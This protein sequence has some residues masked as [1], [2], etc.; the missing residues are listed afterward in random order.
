MNNRRINLI[1]IVVVIVVVLILMSML[2]GPQMGART[3]TR[4]ISC[5][6]NLSSIG[7]AT[8][9]YESQSYYSK[10][11]SV[12]DQQILTNAETGLPI[13]A[14]FRAELID[15]VKVITCP[16]GDSPF[17]V[18]DRDDSNRGNNVFDNS[19]DFSLSPNGQ[20]NYLF[21]LYYSKESDPARVIAGDAGAPGFAGFS[22]NHGDTASGGN[23]AGANALFKDGHV[24]VSRGD[25]TVE[26]AQRIPGATAD[27]N[28]WTFGSVSNTGGGM[29]TQIGCYE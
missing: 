12:H 25:Y 26:G 16:V 9:L 6:G 7:K 3:E 20:T 29:G 8:M 22:P 5:R 27:G 14:L 19:A 24:K 28:L 2:A 13:L 1:E 15:N 18:N 4:K 10:L 11:P 17:G 21:T 23:S